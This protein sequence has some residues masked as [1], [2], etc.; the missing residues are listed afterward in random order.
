M[1]EVTSTNAPIR[2]APIPATRLRVRSSG[3]APQ[4][5]VKILAYVALFGFAQQALTTFADRQAGQLL[6]QAKGTQ[7][8]TRAG[9]SP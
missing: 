6:G 7:T 5:G 3:L 8:A 1:T 9:A 2:D 4:D